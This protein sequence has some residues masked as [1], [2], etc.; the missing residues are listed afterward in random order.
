MLLANPQA[1]ASSPESVALIETH[2]ARVFLAGNEALK[3][4]KRVRLPF[5]DFTTLEAR[6]AACSREMEL[7]RRYAPGI[8]LGLTPITRE[9]NGEL[10][11]A[12]DGEV[13]D[14]A[15]RMRR[16]DQDHLL[17]HVARQGPL[18]PAL[19]RSIAAMVVRYHR[20]CPIIAV[21]DAGGM[22]AV[23]R[24]LVDELDTAKELVS[25]DVAAAFRER[26]EAALDRIAALLGQRAASGAVRRCHGDLHLG[27]IVL[28]HGQPVA[29]DA[30]EFNEALATI[31]VLYDLAFLLM[32][33]EQHGDRPAANVVLNDYCLAAPVGHEIEGLGCLSLFL[34]CR[35]AVRT[36]VAI[37][38]ARQMAGSSANREAPSVAR[39]MESANRYL[40]PPKPAL[41]AVGGLSGTGKSTLAASLA[42][43]LGAAPGAIHLRSDV[44]RKR[45]FGVA[46][47][48]RLGAAQYGGEVTEQVYRLLYDKAERVLASGH[49]VIVDAVFAA[50]EE[51]MAIAA[52]AERAGCA[53]LGLWLEAP[54]ADL[55]ARVEARRG[56]AS[57]ADAAVVRSQLGSDLG[58]MT[59]QRIDAAGTP[60]A[61]L[62]QALSH[63]E[64]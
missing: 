13:V 42:P 21:S 51:R 5:L 60:A 37:E 9:K 24:G 14:W 55:I 46:E 44:E 30:L 41:T 28:D 53:F 56:D 22:R 32:D 18:A 26:A 25:A 15:V 63:V 47:T 59:W 20:A 62:A 7:N 61:V 19:S 11:I 1:Y 36:V 57:D 17:A 48:S 27:N 3:V 40:D 38:R 29:F 50:R 10:A 4:K 39:L 52:V 54:A 33:L 35:V 58:E 8:Y 34:A 12:G 16:F 43:Y 31:D 23:V 45:L 6:R 49:S 2:C 64:T